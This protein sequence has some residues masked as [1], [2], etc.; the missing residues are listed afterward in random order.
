MGLYNKYV[1]DESDLQINISSDTRKHLT[2]LL[3]TK[4]K[5]QVSMMNNYTD[6]MFKIYD[7]AWEQIHKLMRTDSFLRFQQT[8]EY[9]EVVKRTEQENEIDKIEDAK[10]AS[11]TMSMPIT[12]PIDSSILDWNLRDTVMLQTIS[13]VDA[14]DALLEE[15]EEE[16]MEQ[17]DSINEY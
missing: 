6:I 13:T 11:V 17:L 14:M 7:Q 4:D 12:N 5:L 10:S 2:D 9:Q 1:I 3:L 15:D 8:D 16:M